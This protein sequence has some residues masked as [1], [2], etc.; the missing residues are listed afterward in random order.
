MERLEC[1]LRFHWQFVDIVSIQSH[2]STG[3]QITHGPNLG[4]RSTLQHLL[5]RSLEP[6]VPT[7]FLRPGTCVTITAQCCLATKALSICINPSA[8][9]LR[10]Q[11]PCPAIRTSRLI[12]KSPGRW[13]CVLQ[14]ITSS[15]STRT[16]SFVRPGT[17]VAI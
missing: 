5:P 14:E 2:S 13:S 11:D 3:S 7:I 1:H 15:Q 8:S 12:I 16:Q 9:R 6:S 17:S 10:I 4:C